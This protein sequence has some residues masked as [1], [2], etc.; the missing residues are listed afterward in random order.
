[1]LLEPGIDLDQVARLSPCRHQGNPRLAR[2]GHGQTPS[3]RS[4][5]T[6]CL[7]HQTASFDSSTWTYWKSKTAK[8]QLKFSADDTLKEVQ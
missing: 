6:P 7:P 3:R 8:V 4:H 5:F 2:F 1:M